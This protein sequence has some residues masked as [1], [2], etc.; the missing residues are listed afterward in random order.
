MNQV[1]EHFRSNETEIRNYLFVR[2]K[3]PEEFTAVRDVDTENNREC[4]VRHFRF[5]KSF[6]TTTQNRKCAERQHKKKRFCVFLALKPKQK[7]NFRLQ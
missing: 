6:S 5:A 2:V 1:Y 4:A 7:Q 3:Q